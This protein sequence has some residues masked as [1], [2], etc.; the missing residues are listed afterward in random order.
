MTELPRA[1]ERFE[2][3]T[4]I[5]DLRISGVPVWERIRHPVYQA[6]RRANGFGRAHPTANNSVQAYFRGGWLCLRNL[7]IKNP[8]LS[9]SSDIAFVGHP[10]RKREPD[11]TWWDI[12]CDPIHDSLSL[13]SVHFESD[14]QFTH[15]TP[16]KT[17][18]LRYLD[19]IEYG[20]TIQEKLGIVDVTLSTTERER[21]RELET[22]LNH[23]FDSSIN[24]QDR[25]KYTL[26]QR[27]A[28]RW[29]YRRLL[30]QVD[31]ELLIIVVSYGKETVIESCHELDIPV[32]ELQHGIIYP[33][34]FGYSF[35]D[36]R[37]KQAFPDY[38][39]TFGEFWSENAAF[40]IP[41]N[42]V[43]PVG[44][45]YL[46]RRIAEYQDV[47][48]TDELLFISQ[49]TVGDPL[50]K[51]AVEVANHPEIEY[52]VVFKLH[53]SEYDQ[54]RDAYPWLISSNVTVIAGD[55]PPLYELFSRATAQIGFNS[56][57]LFEGLAF[58][59][60]TYVYECAPVPEMQR[61]AEA[62]AVTTVADIEELVTAIIVS[63]QATIDINRLF[64]CDALANV[65]Q[66]LD[67]LVDCGTVAS[68]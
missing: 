17:P 7:I 3:D 53:P 6:I 39:L 60:E 50:S 35:R 47:S 9:A 59:L 23:R 44:Y 31:P 25:I 45:P 10:R 29:L 61:L 24:L 19:L 58:D 20:G 41:E 33:E 16:A 27:R 62:N 66:S 54:W 2:A 65:R 1:F 8:F 48:D 18:R 51:L 5:F 63:E 12:Y 22:K 15:R 28:K 11:G 49:G 42:R 40:P 52:S 13:D 67:R 46:E 36:S 64:K 37:T 14:H 43:I 55:N 34:H 57:A 4:D 68:Y 30:R 56:T 32:V 26:G 38:L 21:I